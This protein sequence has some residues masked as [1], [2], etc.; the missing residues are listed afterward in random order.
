[1]LES[2]AKIPTSAQTLDF[3]DSQK[4][5]MTATQKDRV[6]ENKEDESFIAEPEVVGK[7]IGFVDEK[8]EVWM[9]R[10]TS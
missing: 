5:D 6:S 3:S 1:M 10:I 8:S 4:S 2:I 7:S 9:L